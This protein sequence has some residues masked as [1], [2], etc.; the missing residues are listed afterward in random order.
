MPGVE[1]MKD[2][3]VMGQNIQIILVIASSLKRKLSSE[4]LKEET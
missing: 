2:R 1:I 3:E 4:F